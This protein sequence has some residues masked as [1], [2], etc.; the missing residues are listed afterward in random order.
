M[1]FELPGGKGFRVLAT[2][3]LLFI[4]AQAG[5]TRTAPQPITLSVDA[6]EAPRKILHAH[7]V[8]PAASGPLT[9]VYPK[10]LPGEHGPTGPITDLAGLRLTAMGRNVPWQRDLVDMYA[11]HCEVPTGASAVEVDLDFL[12]PASTEGFTSSASTTAQLAVI[13]WNQV[14]LYPQGPPSDALT[15]TATLH[16]PAGWKFGTALPVDKE[17]MDGISFKP[18]S[19]TTLVDSPVVAGAFFRRIELTPGQT[20]AHYIDMVSDSPAALEMSPELIAEYKQLVAETG[21]LFGAR[22]YTQYHFLYTLSDHVTSFGLEHHESS[23]DR[24]PER[25]L[26]DEAEHIANADLLP[27]EFVHSWNG[28]YRRP[29]GLATPDYQQ[30]MRTDLLWVYEGLTQYLGEVLTA[31]SGLLSPEDTREFIASIAAQLDYRAGRTW[32]PLIDTAVA[33]QL[34]YQAPPSWAAWRRSVDFYNEGVLIWLEADVIIRQR[35]QGRSSLNDFC[36][37]FHGGQSGAPMVNTYTLDDVVKALNDVAPYDWRAFF[38]RE[39][40][41]VTP[42]VPLTGVEGGGWR[43]VYTDTPNH[44]MQA[45]EQT[46][47]GI[48]LSYSL[49]LT[50]NNEGEIVDVIPGQAADKAGL[51]PGMKL[52]AVNGRRASAEVLRQS[53]RATKT[54][55]EPLDLLVENG[56]FYKTYRLN[57][58]GGERYPHLERISER[59]DLLDEIL[60]PLAR[61]SQ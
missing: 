58:H 47:E 6:T 10:W 2:L 9:L 51:G 59:P 32:R 30:P 21:A 26:L 44:Y 24:V 55:S 14:L 61:R 22:H 46:A 4:T 45:Q 40:Y 16:L 37:R 19:L 5:Y 12:L 42:R 3:V 35:T 52:V 38:E 48:D 23:D 34:L 31:R 11:F 18:V 39:V 36:R 13:N 53:V 57:Y 17:S 54:A 28:K 41:N 56:E 15:F 49:G 1:R 29:I 60:K 8:I 7:L 33:A 25:T 50:I 43:L 20:P 27:H